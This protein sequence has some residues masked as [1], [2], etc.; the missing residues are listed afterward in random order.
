VKKD[1]ERLARIAQP[2]ADAP[3]TNGRDAIEE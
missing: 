3:I 1:A 2:E